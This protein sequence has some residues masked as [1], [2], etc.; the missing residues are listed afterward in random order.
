M[1]IIQSLGQL[2][3]MYDKDYSAIIDGCSTQM[4]LAIQDAD[5]LKR[6]SELLGNKTVDVKNTS[7]SFGS[8][9]SD[10]QSINTDSTALMTASQIRRMDPKKCLIFISGEAPF[11]DDKFALEKHTNYPQLADSNPE[12]KFNFREYFY[13]VPKKTEEEEKQLQQ[14]FRS[15]KAGQEKLTGRKKMKVVTGKTASGLS[16][17]NAGETQGEDK[18]SDVEGQVESIRGLIDN[19]TGNERLKK[20]LEDDVKN[21]NIKKNSKGIVQVDHP[22]KEKQFGDDDENSVIDSDDGGIMAYMAG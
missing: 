22:N 18:V 1:V 7:R 3:Q 2:K 16:Q 8:K 9:G 5:D 12:N 14:T 6:V 21:G 4:Y 19:S 20:Q 13:I 17:K 11:L 15:S 10:S